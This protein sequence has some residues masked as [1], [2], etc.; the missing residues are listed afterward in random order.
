MAVSNCETCSNYIY[1]EEMDCY[2]CDMDLDE[3]E[4]IKFL[5]Y[6]FYDCPYYRSDDDYKIVRK[7]N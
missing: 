7:Q 2:C 4:Y 3:D 1:D 6:S 5:S